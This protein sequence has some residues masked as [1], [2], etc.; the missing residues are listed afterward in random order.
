MQADVSGYSVCIV[1]ESEI[2]CR[3]AILSCMR[4][5]FL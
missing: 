2:I 1:S 5:K 3:I 4:G